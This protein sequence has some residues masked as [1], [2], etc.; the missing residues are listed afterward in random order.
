[1]PY[2][3][4]V[5]T[6]LSF[7]WQIS[8]WLQNKNKAS[9]KIS[10]MPSSSII[11]TLIT[12]YSYIMRKTT[13]FKTLNATCHL[14]KLLI[15]WDHLFLCIFHAVFDSMNSIHDM[16][17]NY[18][19]YKSCITCSGGCYIITSHLNSFRK[20]EEGNKQQKQSIDKPCQDLCTHISANVKK[21]WK[22]TS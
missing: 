4:F 20:D 5:V 9:L 21:C 2:S 14:L 12:G 15:D 13:G 3:Y 7:K 19:I 22:C 17:I 10:G 8:D 11:I 18:Y 6:Y 16:D 1:M